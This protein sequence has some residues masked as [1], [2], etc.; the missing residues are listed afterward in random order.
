MATIYQRDYIDVHSPRVKLPP[1]D[2]LP[3]PVREA[4]SNFLRL[5]A[6]QREAVAAVRERERAVREAKAADARALEAALLDGSKGPAKPRA[7]S[8]KAEAA[9]A[10]A[11]TRRD[12]YRRAVGTAAERI[13]EAVAEHRDEWRASVAVD[14]DDAVRRLEQAA[15]DWS[16]AARDL[17]AFGGVL[18]ML[19]AGGAL[20]VGSYRAA[21]A[22]SSVSGP[23]ADAVAAVR[24]QERAADPGTDAEDDDDEP[25]IAV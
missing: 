4:A 11:E 22:L 18:A 16:S 19:D 13:R 5:L 15:R 12:A 6:E 3:G 8:D 17:V 9:L 14:Q 21:A 2:Y 10:D 25:E 7:H 1:L 20:A 23:M 24:D